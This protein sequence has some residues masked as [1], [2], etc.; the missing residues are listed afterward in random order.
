MM[1]F[2]LNHFCVHMMI[3]KDEQI[4][5][6]LIGNGTWEQ[7]QIIIDEMNITLIDKSIVEKSVFV[8]LE[9]RQAECMWPY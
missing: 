3:Y 9:L 1:Q 8:T 4:P 2:H 7:E 6:P 5:T